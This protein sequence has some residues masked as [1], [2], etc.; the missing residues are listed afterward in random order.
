MEKSKSVLLVGGRKVTVHDI[1]NSWNYTTY[2]DVKQVEVLTVDGKLFWRLHLIDK[3]TATF[4]MKEWEL[5][6]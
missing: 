3:T 6:L 1:N 4:S 2:H 5:A